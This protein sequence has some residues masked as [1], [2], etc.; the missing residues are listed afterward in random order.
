[1]VGITPF[2]ALRAL[3]GL[4][5][6]PDLGRWLVAAGWFLHVGHQVATRRPCDRA[7]RASHVTE[8]AMAVRLQAHCSTSSR[9]DLSAIH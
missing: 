3:A 4:A 6:D 9:C 5:V 7:S 2:I 8:G 1:V